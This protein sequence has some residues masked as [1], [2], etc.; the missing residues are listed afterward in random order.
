MKQNPLLEISLLVEDQAK[1]SKVAVIF[2]LDS[3]LFCVSTRTQ[4]ILRHLGH[5]VEFSEKFA[6]ASAILR[7]I[8]VLPTDWGIRSV[9]ERNAFDGPRELFERVR[10]HWRDHFFANHFLKEDVIYPS[11]NEYVQHLHSL[12]AEILYLTG[13]NRSLMETGTREMLKHWGFPYIID[14]KLFMKPDDVQTDEGYKASVLKELVK[15]Y[16]HIWFFENEPLIIH[17]VRA[18]LPQVRV[19][20][21][22]SVHSG[23]AVAPKD[24]PTIGM[25]Y[26]SGL[27]KKS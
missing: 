1:T 3:T 13:R 27:V 19:V 23:R 18:L 14:S 21:V 20:F 7:N 25:S 8:E 2:D 22:D 4:A 9:L 11:A 12:G 24:L 26:A 10:D 6:A 17:E 15:D 5:Q 16:D